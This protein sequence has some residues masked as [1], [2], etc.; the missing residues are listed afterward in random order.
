MLNAQQILQEGLLK[1]SETKG[2]V[3]QVGYD[4]TL[5]AVNKI[6][7]RIG[8]DIYNIPRG[9][10]IGKVLKDKTELTTYTPVNT[11][12]LDDV[13]GWLLYPGTYDIEFWEGVFPHI[14]KCSLNSN[15]IEFICSWMPCVNNGLCSCIG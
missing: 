3:A 12:Q 4:V 1:L 14:C 15:Q 5:K 10:K 2:K 6:G 8:G 9:G 13:E 7:N 11:V